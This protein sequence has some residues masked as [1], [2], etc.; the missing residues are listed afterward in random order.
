MKEKLVFDLI[1]MQRIAEA[2]PYMEELDAKGN[3]IASFWLSRYWLPPDSG[4][5]KDEDKSQYYLKR[6]ESSGVGQYLL[7]QPAE[8]LS[9]IELGSLAAM[10]L[11]GSLGVKKDLQKARLWFKYAAERG[12][13]NA[14]STYSAMLM[15][16]LGGPA[17]SALALKM[18]RKSA[19]R[20]NINAC[21]NYAT[22]LL[23][24]E[25]IAVNYKLCHKYAL[26]GAHYNNLQSMHILGLIYS[27]GLGVAKDLSLSVHYLRR[28]AE[29]GFEA[30]STYL[31]ELYA[32]HPVLRE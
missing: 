14:L 27:G 26:A 12:S 21:G 22:L 20:G 19:D 29:M 32:Q 9:K 6:A 11:D 4:I 18:M 13:A 23:Q 10:Y 2:L 31:E 28:A 8:K 17:D 24:G 15:Q 1:E 25:V 5:R 3:G 30:S 16:G 7:S